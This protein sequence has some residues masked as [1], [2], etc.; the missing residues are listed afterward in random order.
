MALLSTS[1]CRIISLLRLAADADFNYRIIRGLVRRNPSLDIIGIRDLGMV[2]LVDPDV[3][4]WAA[5]SGRVLLTHDVSSMRMYATDRLRNRRTMPGL[6]IG[7]QWLPIGRVID[8][9]LA[10]AERTTGNELANSIVFL[11]LR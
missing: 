11:P 9:I 8:D 6:V 4:E 7:H 5:E 1:A 2:E 3:L 10:L